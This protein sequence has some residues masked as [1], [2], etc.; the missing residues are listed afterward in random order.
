MEKLFLK[1]MT[2]VNESGR[3][4]ILH[5]ENILCREREMGHIYPDLAKAFPYFR[6]MGDRKSVV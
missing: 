4:V 6:R 1:D 2:F 5:G 3:Q